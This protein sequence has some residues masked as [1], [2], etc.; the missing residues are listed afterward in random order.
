LSSEL[1]K[2]QREVK[3]TA[4]N[5]Q[6][7]IDDHKRLNENA[8]VAAELFRNKLRTLE[9]ALKAANTRERE[10]D[11]NLITSKGK[12][13]A[14]GNVVLKTRETL[15]QTRNELTALRAESDEQRSV[16]EKTQRELGS[17]RGDEMTLRAKVAEF[18]LAMSTLQVLHLRSLSQ[19]FYNVLILLC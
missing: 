11:A 6:S 7:S 16:L 4:Q 12:L 5:L 17:V 8:N 9:D 14:Q 18:Q 10:L 2:A 15:E 3:E 19:R 1:E 13:D